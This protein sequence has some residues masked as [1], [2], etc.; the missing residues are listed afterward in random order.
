MRPSSLVRVWRHLQGSWTV[1]HGW[2]IRIGILTPLGEEVQLSE[3]QQ[4]ARRTLLFLCR[5][6]VSS[7]GLNEPVRTPHAVSCSLPI[8]ERKSTI[9]S[10]HLL[11]FFKGERLLCGGFLL[12]SRACYT[13]VFG[14]STIA[15]SP[16]PNRTPLLSCW[17]H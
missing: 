10:M 7:L 9:S 11:I 8:P 4:A 12:S 1:L 16:G 6:L 2:L 17:G 3:T 13:F 15:L 5:L 14:R